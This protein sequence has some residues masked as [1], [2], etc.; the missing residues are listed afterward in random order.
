MGGTRNPTDTR[1][2]ECRV[3][4]GT[5]PVQRQYPGVDS[6]LHSPKLE[7]L[8]R[9]RDSRRTPRAPENK[10]FVKRLLCYWLEYIN[11]SNKERARALRT[12]RGAMYPRQGGSEGEGSYKT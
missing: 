7:R 1:I 11:G 5:G 4:R 6:K 8:E 9:N 3:Q 12:N 2:T 10:T